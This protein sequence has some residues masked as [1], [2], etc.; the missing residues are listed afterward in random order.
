MVQSEFQKAEEAFVDKDRFDV[1]FGLELFELLY[2]SFVLG[3]LNFMAASVCAH[4]PSAKGSEDIDD[5]DGDRFLGSGW[6]GLEGDPVLGSRV[7]GRV[8]ME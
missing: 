6:R 7:S 3:V 1:R 8:I 5:N 4:G 2:Y